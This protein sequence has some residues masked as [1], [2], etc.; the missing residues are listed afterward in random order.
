V[1]KLVHTQHTRI[2][3]DG[4]CLEHYHVQDIAG[5]C[6]DIQLVAIVLDQ[7]HVRLHDPNK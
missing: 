1:V 3:T 4:K 5:R 6:Y 7:R 2:S